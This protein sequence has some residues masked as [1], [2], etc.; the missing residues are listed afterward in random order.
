MCIYNRGSQTHGYNP[1]KGH[2]GFSEGY[3]WSCKKGVIYSLL[4]Y[5]ASEVNIMK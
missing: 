3:R 2:E 4:P 5:K 1:I